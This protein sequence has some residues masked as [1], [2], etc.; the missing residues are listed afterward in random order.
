MS[1]EQN[2][3]KV[4]PSAEYE[5]LGAAE[6]ENILEH[7]GDA[8]LSLSESDQRAIRDTV[9]PYAGNASPSARYALEYIHERFEETRSLDFLLRELKQKAEI[10]AN[11]P[12]DLRKYLINEFPRWVIEE[13]LRANTDG[14][15]N[16]RSR[17]EYELEYNK[18]GTTW[19]ELPFIGSVLEFFTA[20]EIEG[21]ITYNGVIQDVWSDHF[22]AVRF[23][24]EQRFTLL[25]LD[26]A[27]KWTGPRIAEIRQFDYPLRWLLILIVLT[28]CVDLV[29]TESRDVKDREETARKL[30][31]TYASACVTLRDTGNSTLFD[32]AKHYNGDMRKAAWHFTHYL[33]HGL[34]KA[35]TPKDER[36]V[37]DE[38]FYL[39]AILKTRFDYISADTRRSVV[40]PNYRVPLNDN[41]FIGKLL[42]APT[43]TEVT[44][45]VKEVRDPKTR[46]LIYPASEF[47]F[48][49]SSK[50]EPL[51]EA[52]IHVLFALVAFKDRND[53]VI[54]AFGFKSWHVKL[55]D[56]VSQMFPCRRNNITEDSTPY[57]FVKKSLE[58][59]ENYR[60]AFNIE[61]VLKSRGYIQDEVV[62]SRRGDT[63]ITG[64]WGVVGN[65]SKR[66]ETFFLQ[67]MGFLVPLFEATQ[68][69]NTA[70]IFRDFMP[71]GINDED[72]INLVY[73]MLSRAM[74]RNENLNTVPLYEVN[75]VRASRR[76]F[77]LFRSMK[78]W[79]WV[80]ITADNAA[81]LG[82][83]AE[84]LK[85]R[86]RRQRERVQSI[87]D[88]W[89]KT[90]CFT[91]TTNLT[92][93]AKPKSKKLEWYYARL[94]I[95]KA[96]R[97]L[98]AK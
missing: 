56:L 63:M 4:N 53:P 41:R 15:K 51:S 21:A 32:L 86:D 91:I 38:W 18:T 64:K 93:K 34:L 20:E 74:N 5:A 7:F 71:S 42:T 14:W 12:E 61:Q 33:L 29:V 98:L 82:I 46:E 47:T 83:S 11:A 94:D 13:S 97:K 54:D 3:T 31:D 92:D 65:G 85:Q 95:E 77:S 88:F 24:G 37:A 96:Q 79:G 50:N 28:Q 43:D 1:L 87:L 75:E 2:N 69:S 44:V 78:P 22:M 89:A 49:V 76:A 80:D 30:L 70:L 6:T 67:G 36:D 58:R 48:A 62:V 25:S 26:P 59:L 39:P 19:K 17:I 81:E 52:D 66:Y 27:K 23:E 35:K 16:Y 72:I 55:V 68:W 8:F 84:A 10:I 9:T 90:G 40:V 45:P 60:H 73:T 57:K